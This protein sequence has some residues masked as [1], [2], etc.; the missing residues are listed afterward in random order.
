MARPGFTLYWSSLESYEGCP[1]QF[2]WSRGWPGFDV[3][4]GDGRKKPLPERK[5][6]HHALMGIT[7][8]YAVERMYND[9]LWRDPKALPEVL[10]RH[11]EQEWDRLVAKPDNWIDYAQAGDRES[12]LTI[13]RNGVAGF[14]RGFIRLCH[15]QCN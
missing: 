8:Q 1:Q 11:V 13:C 2:L 6:A 12:L 4:G 10:V 15:H 3:G 9:E 14:L 7:I 5:T